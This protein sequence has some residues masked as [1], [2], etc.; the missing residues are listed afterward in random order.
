MIKILIIGGRIEPIISAN[1]VCVQNLLQAD[2]RSDLNV[3]FMC[4]GDTEREFL[5]EGITYHIFVPDTSVQRRS[6]IN[7]LLALPQTDFEETQR[8][9]R[10]AMALHEKYDFQ[11]IIGVNCP[12][13]NVA[14]ALNVKKK[15]PSIFAVGYYLDILEGLSQLQGIQRYVRDMFSYSGELK[16]LK[17]LDWIFMPISAQEIYLAPKYACVKQKMTFLEFPSFVPDIRPKEI[18]ERKDTKRLNLVFIG[19][20]DKK[21]RD[22]TL[23]FQALSLAATNA[24]LIDVDIYGR[25][26]ESFMREYSNLEHIRF[27]IKGP[28]PH[29]AIKD[30]YTRADAVLNISNSNQYVVPS[31]VFEIASYYRPMIVSVSNPKDYAL[32][33]YRQYEASFIICGYKKL[34]DQ[35]SSLRNFLRELQSINVNKETVDKVF[36]ENTPARVMNKIVNSLTK[37]GGNHANCRNKYL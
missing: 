35:I 34:E 24:M 11:Y 4:V 26:E 36:A 15:Y 22:P 23:L 33:Y 32:R 12:F 1:V 25:N 7:R 27:N 37:I 21:Y 3:H 16:A 18:P 6:M 5:Y 8:K 31:K 20:L 29:D 17:K 10:Q 28:I 14:A 19:T 2:L 13:S 9:T 30:I